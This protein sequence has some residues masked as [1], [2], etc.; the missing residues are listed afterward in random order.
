KIKK[1]IISNIYDNSLKKEI[2]KKIYDG[3]KTSILAI[4]PLTR[5]KIPIW[6]AN[7]VMEKYGTNA[8]LSIPGHNKY[9]WHFAIQNK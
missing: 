8:I 2:E 3:I 5:K 1:F 9:D 6:I 7:F 4:H